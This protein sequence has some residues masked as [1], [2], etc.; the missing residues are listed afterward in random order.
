MDMRQR[1]ALLIIDMVKDN[2]DEGKKLPITPLARRIIG[3]INNL[4]GVFRKEKW[5]VVFSTDAF[6]KEDFIF[7]GRMKPHS[8]AGTQGAEVVEELDRRSEDLWVPKP[9]F[10]AFFGTG[11]AQSLKKDNVTLCAV[12]GIATNF[13]VL[14]TVMDAIC[15]DFQAVLLEDCS[16]SWS[17]EIH[18]QT[19]NLYRHNP[20]YPLLRVSSSTELAADLNA[21]APEQRRA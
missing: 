14:T 17:E 21:G 16:A 15:S 4:I 5:P 19:V 9:R 12:A 18:G 8:L 13:C 7:T 10:S 20:L 1:P 6:R 2:F 11:L 3:P